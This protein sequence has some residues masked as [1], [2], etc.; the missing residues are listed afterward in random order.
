[1]DSMNKK[2]VWPFIIIALTFGIWVWLIAGG[3]V[4]GI[5]TSSTLDVG[6]DILM[7]I[8]SL[9]LGLGLYLSLP[10]LVFVLVIRRRLSPM[11]RLLGIA[12]AAITFLFYT[13]GLIR[14]Y[15]F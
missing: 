7:P 11:E 12:P 15:F 10:L 4:S 14:E 6:F 13:F 2:A 5:V 8:L 1:M 3:I 9:F